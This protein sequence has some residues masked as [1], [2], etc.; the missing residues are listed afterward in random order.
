MENVGLNILVAAS[1]AAPVAKAGG[2][3]DVVGS[4]PLALRNLGCRVVVVLPAYRRAVQEIGEYRVTARDIPVLLGESK[5]TADVLVGKLAPG[6][7]LCLLKR[8]EFFDRSDLYGD[9]RGEYKDNTERFIFFSRS[10]P[11]FCSAAGFEPDVILA[12]DWQTGLVMALMAEGALPRTAGVFAIH[13]MGYLGL[14]PLERISNIG[15][16]DKYYGM[17][18]LEYYGQMSLLKAG[19]VYAH[20]VTTVSPTYSLEVQ[21][22]KLG[23]GL[24]GLMRSVKDRLYGILNGIDHEE[25]NPARDRHLAASYSA[26][27]L[28]GKAHCKQDLLTAM[29]LPAELLH[30]PLA[31]VV[32]RLVDQ[33]G[34]QLLAD[35]AEQLFA[36]DMGIVLL[37]S[38]EERYHRLFSRLQAQWPG[39]FGLKLGY[40]AVLAHKI[41]AGCDMFLA[42]SLYEPCGLTQMFSLRYGTIP[43]VRATGGLKDTVTDPKE[44]RG[45]GTGFK[46]DLFAVTDLVTA[47]GRAV[48]TFG[49]PKA[50]E[51]MMRQAMAQ[52]FSWA[53]P[54][55]EYLRVFERALAARR[56][57]DFQN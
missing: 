10:I 17:D 4:L 23:S 41:I 28:S 3:G 48:K 15:L 9:S 46:F 16:P 27:N 34:C 12:N 57:R 49:D 30:R 26:S 45:P 20:A 54:A 44:G 5:L 18:G 33:K 11:A 36:M 56:G 22:P 50:W 47:V 43:V 2:L 51:A 53:R 32:T 24:E 29:E 40:D 31:G 38:G 25:W 1:E 42:P 6:I 35:A 19:I 37:G 7:P 52:D 21:T 13:N 14:V 55:R 8:D 39:L